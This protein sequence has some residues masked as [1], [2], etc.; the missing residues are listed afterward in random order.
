MVNHKYGS[1]ALTSRHGR[2]RWAPSVISAFLIGLV[3]AGAFA[4]GV[5]ERSQAAGRSDD[6]SDDPSGAGKVSAQTLTVRYPRSVSS[7]PMLVMLDRYPQDYDGAFFTDHAQALAQLINGQTD[8]LATG[9][10]VGY[11]RYRSSG[12]L[13]H[14]ATPVWGVSALMTREAVDAVG[15]LSGGTVY[16]PFEGSPIDFYLKAVLEEAGVAD[17]VRIAYAP[18]PQAAALLAQGK[19]DG[20]VLVEP[21]ASKLEAGGQ[22]YRLENLHEGW[23]RINSGEPRSPQVSLFATDA[24]WR[25]AVG[26]MSLLIQRYTESLAAVESNPAEYAEKYADDLGFPAPIVE[27]ALANTLFDLPNHEETGRII[28]QYTQLMGLGVPGD[29]FY[30]GSQ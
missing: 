16:A 1:G 27:R 5:D 2:R 10:S 22:A 19:A 3:A 30:A 24:G 12:D 11:S 13:V 14:L 9:F 29:A 4:L 28:R 26:D 18:F 7:V 8:V 17:S 23:A 15:D 25:E 20:A 6:L 21:L